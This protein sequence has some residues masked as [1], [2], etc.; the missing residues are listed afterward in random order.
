MGI[1]KFKSGFWGKT[2]ADLVILV[3]F[4]FLC[5]LLLFDSTVSLILFSIS[6]EYS[7]ERLRA[8]GGIPGNSCT[9]RKTASNDCKSAPFRSHFS[10]G[11]LPIYKIA[12]QGTTF[13]WSEHR[14]IASTD[15]R[16]NA[17]IYA[18]PIPPDFIVQKL[19]CHREKRKEA[20]IYW[21]R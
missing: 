2:L 9:P 14:Y 7:R 5:T 15:K 11:F 1:V 10:L 16:S 13:I 18:F 4:C 12:D 6:S 21:R 20:T 8:W 17:P 19:C 3:S